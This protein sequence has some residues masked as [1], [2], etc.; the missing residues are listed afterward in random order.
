[1]W[2]LSRL[3]MGWGE[4]RHQKGVIARPL[5]FVDWADSDMAIEIAYLRLVTFF[6]ELL[7]GRPNFSHAWPFLAF[8][9][10]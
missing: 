9:F 3:G 8:L 10:C 4:R 5:L 7:L 1:L 6:S 2:E